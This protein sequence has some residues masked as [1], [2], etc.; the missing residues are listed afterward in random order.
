[1]PVGVVAVN[2]VYKSLFIQTLEGRY[3]VPRPGP[4]TL[5]VGT[6]VSFRELIFTDAP[7]GFYYA[8]QIVA[9]PAP[10]PPVT[11]QSPSVPSP[12][13]NSNALTSPSSP[14]LP[15]VWGKVASSNVLTPSNPGSNSSPSP[16][17]AL[18]KMKKNVGPAQMPPSYAPKPLTERK[19]REDFE[20]I[21]NKVDSMNWGQQKGY[22]PSLQVETKLKWEGEGKKL[23]LRV[24]DEYHDKPI[25]GQGLYYYVG[26]MGVNFGKAGF[27]ISAH[28][29]SYD[30]YKDKKD[31]VTYTVLHIEN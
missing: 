16:A 12:V 7:P 31:K 14:T 13:S 19:T 20:A 29:V 24:K 10:L 27:R 11:T 25:P 3:Y 8:D 4:I 22:G 9:I 21:C 1:M 23:Y 28:T 6:L 5:P 17:V 15:G 2:H 18:T 30:K 26:T